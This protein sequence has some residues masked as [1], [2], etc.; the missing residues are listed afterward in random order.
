MFTWE[1]SNWLPIRLHDNLQI[2]IG[3]LFFPFLSCMAQHPTSF[4]LFF[5]R[6]KE[7]KRK[8]N[9]NLKK[10]VSSSNIYLFPFLYFFFFLFFFF[11]FIL[12]SFYLS[13]PF[14]SFYV[15]FLSFFVL[16]FLFI[17]MLGLNV[18][19]KTNI[20]FYGTKSMERKACRK[21]CPF[22][23]EYSCHIYGLTCTLNSSNYNQLLLSAHNY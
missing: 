2:L 11:G 15:I 19:Y 8:M 4:S 17:Y 21:G 3:L 7:K 20:S 1:A 12:L 13:F 16:V 18:F 10:S 23:I 22:H 9:K 14:C 6:K 5:I